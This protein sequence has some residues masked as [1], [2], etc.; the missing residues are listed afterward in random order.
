MVAVEKNQPAT[1]QI[2]TEPEVVKAEI[3][4]AESFCS[5]SQFLAYGGSPDTFV[6]AKVSTQRK[7]RPLL[8]KLASSLRCSV[9]FLRF[10]CGVWPSTGRGVV[11]AS[12]ICSAKIKRSG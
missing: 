5:T 11:R 4:S 9:S 10:A 8:H 3:S 1:I 7:T 6:I 12:R 2:A